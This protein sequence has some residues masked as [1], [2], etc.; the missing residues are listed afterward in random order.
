MA[1]AEWSSPNTVY[2]CHLHGVLSR[3]RQLRDSGLSNIANIQHPI[4]LAT[5]PHM[6]RVTSDPSIT[7]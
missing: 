7:V 6:N 2:C 4:I 1:I 3:R 5:T